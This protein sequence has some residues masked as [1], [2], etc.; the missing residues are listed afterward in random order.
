[1]I[2]SFFFFVVIITTEVIPVIV[3]S[4]FCII[5]IIDFAITTYDYY[6]TIKIKLFLTKVNQ[7]FIFINLS[8]YQ[9]FSEIH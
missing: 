4:N 8:V 6:F 5:N 3:T 1:M 7:L 9:L 2:F